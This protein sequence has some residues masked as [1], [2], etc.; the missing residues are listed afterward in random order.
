MED[1]SEMMR[2]ILRYSDVEIP[3]KYVAAKN[4]IEQ[5]INDGG[6]VIVW[7]CYIKNIEMFRDYLKSVGI[8][9]RT[10]YGATPVAGG[11]ISEED[12]EDNGVGKKQT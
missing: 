12:D 5:I 11:S 2:E 9:S 6:K 4:I 1:D 7:A 8:E 10:L 3:A